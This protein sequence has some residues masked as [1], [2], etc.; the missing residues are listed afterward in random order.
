MISLHLHPEGRLVLAVMSLLAGIC[1][2]FNTNLGL[3]HSVYLVAMFLLLAFLGVAHDLWRN[4]A[5]CFFLIIAGAFYA[6]WRSEQVSIRF[7]ERSVFF[8]GSATVDR[9]DDRAGGFPRITFINLAA[10]S[11]R[12]R[13]FQK[14]RLNVRTRIDDDLLPGDRVRLEARLEPIGGKLAP[15]GYDFRRAAFFDGIEASGFAI[16]PVQRIVGADRTPNIVEAARQRIARAVTEAI[17][18]DAGKL[19]AAL[20][21]GKR[22]A[23]SR[24]AVENMRDAGLAH[25]LAISGLHMG[26]FVGAAFFVIETVLLL[27]P[28]IALRYNC[29]KIAAVGAF[30]TATLYLSLSGM[31]IATVRAYIVAVVALIAILLD[32]RVVSFRSL[33]LAALGIMLISPQAVLGA[34]FQMSFAATA[35]LVIFYE[36]LR[37]RQ[38]EKDIS[39]TPSQADS[40]GGVVSRKVARFILYTCLTTIVAQIAVAP[41]SLFH[42]QTLPLFGL[43]ANIVAVPT[44]LFVVVPGALISLCL[45]PFGLEFL[46]VPFVEWGLNQ[47]LEIARFVAG[48]EL[49]QISIMPPLDLAL[50]I[51]LVAGSGVVLFNGTRWL[52]IAGLGLYLASPFMLPMMPPDMIIAPNGRGLVLIEDDQTY[53][54]A[55][56]E[57]GFAYRNYIAQWPKAFRARPVKLSWACDHGACRAEKAKVSHVKSLATLREECVSSPIVIL[58]RRW[59]NFCR[60]PSVILTEEELEIKGP[61][62]FYRNTETQNASLRWMNDYEGSYKPWHR[63]FNNRNE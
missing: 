34:G 3:P 35:G 59:R 8:E 30:F 13:S 42:F 7:L 45:I 25:M 17:E 23:L 51:S 62:F 39:G 11:E 24:E 52:W 20:I 58:P 9:I 37:G 6:D 55:L 14:V 33:A 50:L 16:K 26:L 2:Y 4:V 22:G 44:L 40:R 46:T 60:G 32:R 15:N 41:F 48:L 29:R 61:V 12:Y 18:G 53:T 21:V 36:R 56:R 63:R 31:S 5:L 57:D 43:L 10:G 47:I 54:M 28:F 49:G 27:I 19:A 1:L 38:V